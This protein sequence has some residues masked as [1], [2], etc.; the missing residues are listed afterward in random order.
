MQYDKGLGIILCEPPKVVKQ[1]G[2]DEIYVVSVI[3]KLPVNE[4]SIHTKSFLETWN[5]TYMDVKQLWHMCVCTYMHMN[6]IIPFFLSSPGGFHVPLD[7][8]IF[9]K[10]RTILK[11]FVTILL[12][13]CVLVFFFWSQ[14]MWILALRPEIEPTSPALE[15]EVLTTGLPGKS[16]FLVFLKAFWETTPSMRGAEDWL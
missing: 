11:V 15:G 10:I 13:F 6:T 8:R 2:D 7:L 4:F 16:R 5:L 12:L 3:F 9:F 1:E 14:N